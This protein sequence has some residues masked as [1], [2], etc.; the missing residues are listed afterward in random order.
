MQKLIP[1]AELALAVL[2]PDPTL[3]RG[4]LVSPCELTSWSERVDAV[5]IV[6]EAVGIARGGGQELGHRRPGGGQ[7]SLKPLSPTL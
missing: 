1:P 3:S 5:Y 6:D 2:D 7:V 4:Q